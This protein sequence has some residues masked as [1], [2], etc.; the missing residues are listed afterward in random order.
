MLGGGLCFLGF[1]KRGGIIARL[2]QILKTLLRYRRVDLLCRG[3]Q[4]QRVRRNGE[5][6]YR[7]SQS[8]PPRQSH[9]PLQQNRPNM[10][11]DPALC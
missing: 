9:A 11:P 3:G 10:I 7:N 6:D 4:Q 5:H 8:A 2:I 1:C